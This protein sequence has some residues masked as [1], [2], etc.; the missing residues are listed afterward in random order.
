MSYEMKSHGKEII[1][2]AY[3]KIAE[4]KKAA[5]INKLKKPFKGEEG[6]GMS[7]KE[8]NLRGKNVNQ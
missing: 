6:K 5:L 8:E 2:G 7:K 1:K 3:D 4:K